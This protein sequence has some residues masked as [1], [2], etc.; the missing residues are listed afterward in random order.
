M[1]KRLLKYTAIS[2]VT[3]IAFSCS[4]TNNKPII[5][6]SADSSSIVI[7]NI[8]EV[9]LLQVK[10]TMQANPDSSHLVNVLLSP[11]DEDSLQIEQEIA[12]KLI[13]AGDSLIFK[14]QTAFLKGK[15]YLVESYI[16]VQFGN[17]EK[18]LKGTL[19]YRLE[20]QQVILKR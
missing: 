6:F 8:E 2:L 18:L 5:K 3:V 14:P 1:Y 12:G 19:K 10:N 16:D 7:K 15:N 9:S 11:G 13:L 20:P 4:D 17:K